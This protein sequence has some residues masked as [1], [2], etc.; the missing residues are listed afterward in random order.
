MNTTRNSFAIES[1]ADPEPKGFKVLVF[2]CKGVGLGKDAERPLRPIFYPFLHANGQPL[3]EF[4]RPILPV[5]QSPHVRPKGFANDFVCDLL[6]QA[7]KFR[8]LT[9]H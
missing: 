4:E 7:F 1:A 5:Q 8:T 3:P 9:A 6:Q 2:Q